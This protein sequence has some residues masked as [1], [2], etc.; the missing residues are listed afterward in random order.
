MNRLVYYIVYAIS[1]LPLWVLY[2][3]SDLFYLLLISIIPYR[4]AVIIKNLKASFPNSNKRELNK[5]KKEVYRHFSDLLI[6]GIKKLDREYQLD[7]PKGV[8]GRSSNNDLVKKVLNWSYKIKLKE[9]LQN[10]YNWI[11]SETSK[12]GSNLNRFTKSY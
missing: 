1:L 10:T 6:E 7:K 4:K 8:R 5:L 9:G 12:T 2:I 3:F 11:S